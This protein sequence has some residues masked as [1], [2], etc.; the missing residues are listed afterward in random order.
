MD[1]LASDVI[2][3]TECLFYSPPPRPSW[4]KVQLTAKS[5]TSAAPIPDIVL[6]CLPA[7]LFKSPQQAPKVFM[8]G[9]RPTN[10]AVLNDLAEKWE[11]RSSLPCTF[12]P[13]SE[14]SAGLIIWQKTSWN[15][16][17]SCNYDGDEAWL[18]SRPH[19]FCS[20]TDRHA[21]VDLGGLGENRD[22]GEF[23]S[24][25]LVLIPKGVIKMSWNM[26]LLDCPKEVW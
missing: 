24:N 18:L 17:D 26:D 2:N 5:R 4:E 16:S 21:A 23:E 22:V 25:R 15:R 7:S 9:R 19:N 14:H 11:P 3:R 20:V 6:G 8:E 10:C 1:L 12:S 13:P